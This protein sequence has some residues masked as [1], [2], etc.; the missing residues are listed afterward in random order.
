MPKKATMFHLPFLVLTVLGGPGGLPVPPPNHFAIDLKVQGAK[1]SRTAHAE[2][3]KR[4]AKPTD[5]PL[6]EAKAGELLTVHWTLRR[7]D[8]RNP[9]KDILVHFVVVQEGQAG[10]PTI[11][12]LDK[13]VAVE[14]AL[15]MDF[16]P[17]DETTG[18][19]SFQVATPGAYLVRLETIGAS[20]G[21]DGEETFAALDLVAR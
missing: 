9:A 7:T 5:R 10:Q 15:T 4:G 3:P 1:A 14:S 19:L 20:Q 12:R 6:L 18:D 11:P 21:A 17:K 2:T 16:Q 13:G 8:L